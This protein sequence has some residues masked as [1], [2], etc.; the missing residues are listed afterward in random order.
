[1]PASSPA[2]RSPRT[3][4]NTW[5]EAQSAPLA[6][7]GD[8][9]RRPR[10]ALPLLAPGCIRPPRFRPPSS[11]RGQGPAET[12][13]W[14]GIRTHEGLPPAGF[15]DRCL[16]PLG[17]PS[18]ARARQARRKSRRGARSNP[19]PRRRLQII[20]RGRGSAVQCPPLAPCEVRR[21]DLPV[22]PPRRACRGP[23]DDPGAE[24]S[25]ERAPTK[26]TRANGR[27]PDGAR[28]PVRARPPVRHA[29]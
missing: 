2:R 25:I 14:G 5:R 11:R 10:A 15:Q 22:K 13:G 4:A 28:T 17:H 6:P 19:A 27:V 7:G 23:A 16:Q 20:D 9:A 29:A 26:N 1:M 21:N 8:G 3:A 12:G 18:A 24:A